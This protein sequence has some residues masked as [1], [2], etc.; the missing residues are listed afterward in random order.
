[1]YSG[2][3]IPSGLSYSIYFISSAFDFAL[4]LS[5]PQ[6]LADYVVALSILAFETVLSWA[7]PHLH[8]DLLVQRRQMSS[9][10]T[11]LCGQEKKDAIIG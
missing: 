11:N 10:G 2:S 6:Y 5:A 9:P 3:R 7:Q 1:M 4:T 8:I